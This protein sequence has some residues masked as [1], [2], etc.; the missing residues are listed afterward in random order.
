MPRPLIILRKQ[1]GNTGW[2]YKVRA[3]LDG[4]NDS[5]TK[6]LQDFTP[7]AHS[8]ASLARLTRMLTDDPAQVS[9]LNVPTAGRRSSTARAC[10]TVRTSGRET[11]YRAR[12]R[13]PRPGSFR[14]SASA[15]TAG[16]GCSSLRRLRLLC[17]T[18]VSG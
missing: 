13:I 14:R 10:T 18:S 2:R 12:T 11:E 17:W 4:F 8:I 16:T 5:S 15:R 3:L 1:P 7:G 9:G 6:V